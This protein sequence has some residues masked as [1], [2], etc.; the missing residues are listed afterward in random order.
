MCGREEFGTLLR[1]VSGASGT[2]NN[3]S[4]YGAPGKCVTFY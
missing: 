2:L 3:Y 1:S 4:C